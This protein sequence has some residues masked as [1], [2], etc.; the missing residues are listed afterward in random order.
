MT[1][2]TMTAV[3]LPTKSSR[4][5]VIPQI[6]NPE[7][8]LSLVREIDISTDASR[9]TAV[10]GT[11]GE[12]IVT[13]KGDS[14]P[15]ID[16]HRNDLLHSLQHMR[17]EG[18][19]EMTFILMTQIK[20]LTFRAL[21]Y[22][23]FNMQ[24][25]IQNDDVAGAMQFGPRIKRLLEF[26]VKSWDVLSTISTQGFNEF[27]DQ[28]GISSG[29]QSYVYRHVEFILG[30]K[31]R[32]LAEAHVNN[33]DVYPALEK[34]LNSPSLYD[35]VIRLL[36]RRGLSIPAECLDRDWSADYV[37]Q[38]AIEKAWIE[39]HQDPTPENDLYQLSELLTEIA[40]V[41]SQYRWR[42]FVSVQRILGLKPGTG[43]SAGVGWLKHV[44]ELRF[45]PELWSIR[46][47][48]GA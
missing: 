43:G 10:K 1:D 6:R 3:R 47:F 36:A 31:S 30:N 24:R 4:K 48:L 14:N 34:A 7:L 46:T 25:R 37:P 28:L 12:P 17:S 29:Q 22:E 9:N 23:L 11:N 38:V 19:D 15:Y 42:H 2:Q 21:H 39:V 40:D 13:F 26:L 27:R 16:Y 45:F 32:R 33:P 35:D 18:H 44:V 5:R 41:F 20:E 8:E